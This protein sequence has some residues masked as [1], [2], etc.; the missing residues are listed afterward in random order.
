MNTKILTVSFIVRSDTNCISTR[1]RG[2]SQH[3]MIMQPGLFVFGTMASLQNDQNGNPTW[4]V[5]G[6]WK[7]RLSS[8]N[9]TQGAGGSQTDAASPP[10]ATSSLAGLPNATLYSKFDMDPA[11]IN[12]HFGNTPVFG[13]IEKLLTVDK[14]ICK[15]TSH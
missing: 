11:M 3:H 13:T 1:K 8:D 4:I 5:S 6:I 10:N 2:Y 14:Y 12:N 9:K 7:G 15:T